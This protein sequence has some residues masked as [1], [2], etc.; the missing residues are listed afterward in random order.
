[1]DAN[2]STNPVT[3]PSPTRRAA[4]PRPPPS[5]PSA[6]RWPSSATRVL[7]VDLDPQ[8]CL[9]FSLGIDPEDLEHL[10]PPRPDQGRGPDRGDHRDRGRRRPPAGDHRARPRR[11]RPAHPHRARARHQGRARAARRG[12]RRRGL[13]LGA[14]RLPALAR[15]ADRR[16]A[17]RRRRRTD[18]AAVRDALAPRRRAAA[19]HRPRRTPLHQPR[20]GG[21]GRPARRST[22]GAPTTRGPCWRRSA[23]PTTSRSSSR[24]SPRRSSSPRPLPPAGRSCRPAAAARAPRPTARWPRTSSCA[25]RGP[26]RRAAKKSATKR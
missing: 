2:D 23:R 24:R 7:L 19:R 15:G 12:P 4:S 3:S 5:P 6:P 20:P 8:A 26:G 17:D 16:G 14:A 22:T 10:R 1:M 9:T 21:V 25:L 13:R 11:G 18:P